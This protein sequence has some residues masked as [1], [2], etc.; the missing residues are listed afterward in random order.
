MWSFKARVWVVRLT[1][2]GRG[3]RDN[4]ISRMVGMGNDWM[5]INSMIRTM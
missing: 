5:L 2:L 1:G 3:W 4:L